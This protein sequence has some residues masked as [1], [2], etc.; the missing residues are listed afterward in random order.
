MSPNT[1]LETRTVAS[2]LAPGSL[3]RFGV[4]HAYVNVAELESAL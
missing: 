4:F 3:E 1:P 2:G